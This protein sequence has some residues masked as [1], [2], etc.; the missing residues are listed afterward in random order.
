MFALLLMAALASN[1]VA[2]TTLV[3]SPTDTLSSGSGNALKLTPTLSQSGTA[4]YTD[5]FVNRTENSTGSGPQLF[6]QFQVGG[7]D[8]WSLDR[9]G[10]VTLGAWNGSPISVAFGGTG[11]TSAIAGFNALSPMTTL[12]DVIY[13]GASGTATRLPG[14]TT[15]TKNFLV[16]TGT[17]S[18]SAAPG[19]STIQSADLPI[20]GVGTIGGVSVDGTTITIAAG[21]ISAVAGSNSDVQVFTS[22]GTWTKPSGSPKSVLVICWGAGGGAG[23]GAGAAANAVRGGGA[24]GGGGARITATFNAAALPSSVAVTVGAAGNGGSG[25]SAS[26]GGNG[27]A[28]TQSTFGS[29]VYAGGGGGGAGAPVGNN[30]MAAGGGGGGGAGNGGT[31]NGTTAG[32]GSAPG[33]TNVLSAMGSQGPQGS[34]QFGAGNAEYGGGGGAGAAGGGGSGYPGGSSL[35]G[36]GAGGG[37]GGYTAAGALNLGAAG[38]SSGSYT[39]GGGGAAGASGG[40]AGTNGASYSTSNTPSGMGGGG[41]GPNSTGTGGVGGTGGFPAGGGGGGGGGTSTGGTG[42]AGGGGQVIVITIY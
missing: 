19:W 24:S 29:Y 40:G 9:T 6:E 5:I 25:G 41:G 17:G 12:G 26:A 14:N 21:V 20:A 37:G 28:G 7:V 23:G 42:G 36:G 27:S 35:F 18:V 15:A 16:Q 39:A 3:Y 13:G 8:K 11:Q 10:T 38:G 30:N 32:A 2:Q 31:G 33:A 22:S 4:G 1:L 34:L